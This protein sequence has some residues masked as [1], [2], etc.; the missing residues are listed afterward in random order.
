MFI[1]NE[2][3]LKNYGMQLQNMGMEIHNFGL[4]MKNNMML[5]IGNQILIQNIGD[6]IQNMGNQIS[7]IAMQI[8]NMGIQIS[9][10]IMNQN[11]INM[12]N[13]NNLMNNNMMMNGIN[14]EIM[15]DNNEQ[16]IYS[17]VFITQSGRKNNININCSR[18]VEDLLNLYLNRMG[19]DIDDIQKKKIFFLNNGQKMDLKDKS[20]IIEYFP[21]ISTNQKIEVIN[22]Y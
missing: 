10:I 1:D 2:N 19:L 6:Q 4:Q 5:N 21:K 8:F 18:T 9:N 15:N 13:Q 22:Y 14:E 16:L 12:M 20:K 11:N 17:V 3:Q 7:N